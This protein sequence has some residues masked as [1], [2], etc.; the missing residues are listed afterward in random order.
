MQQLNL[1]GVQQGDALC[2]INPAA[3]SR[4]SLMSD[5]EAGGVRAIVYVL[6]DP[7]PVLTYTAASNREAL[8]LLGLQSNFATQ[9]AKP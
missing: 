7:H 6:G 2:L 5:L 9:L 3:I 8:S 1:V 4:I